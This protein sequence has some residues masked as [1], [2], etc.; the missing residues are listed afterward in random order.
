MDPG[1]ALDGAAINRDLIVYGFLDLR[2]GD[3]HV[4][5]LA[6]DIGEL[7]ADE[8][9]ALFLYHADDIVLGVFAH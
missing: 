7:H 3:G 6:K 4:F 8:V 2:G 9:N 5:G 1:K